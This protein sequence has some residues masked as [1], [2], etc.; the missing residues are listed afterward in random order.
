MDTLPSCMDWDRMG[1][2]KTA[3]TTV[4]VHEQSLIYI[5]YGI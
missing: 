4:R 5:R 3:A 1:Q 2:V